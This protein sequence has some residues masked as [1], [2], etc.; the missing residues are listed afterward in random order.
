MIKSN[1]FCAHWNLQTII[2][3]M[4]SFNVIFHCSFP[5]DFT[6]LK[7]ALQFWLQFLKVSLSLAKQFQLLS[8][9]QGEFYC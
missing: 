1:M 9:S 4:N 3:Q 7:V 5:H 6:H 8:V 2:F